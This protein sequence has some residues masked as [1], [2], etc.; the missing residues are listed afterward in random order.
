MHGMHDS[1]VFGYAQ[2]P[3]NLV[4]S[5]VLNSSTA[6]RMAWKGQKLWKKI[7]R[8]NQ[9][10]ETQIITCREWLHELWQTTI[11][12]EGNLNHKSLVHQFGG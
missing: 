12:E 10:N 11:L 9:R 4:P 7:Q 1:T 6:S 8:E 3:A 5:Y 2:M